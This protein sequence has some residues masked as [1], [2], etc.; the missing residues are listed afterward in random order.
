MSALEK[1][2][3]LIDIGHA[4]TAMRFLLAYLSIQNGEYTLTGSER[5]RQRPVARL[6]EALLGLGARIEYLGQKGFPPLSIKGKPLEGG[7]ITVDGSISSQYISA[8]MMIGPALKNGLVITLENEVVS[9][10]YIRMT[11][12]LMLEYGIGVNLSGNRIEVPPCQ[13]AGRD[14]DTEADWSAAGYW[15]AMAALSKQCNLEVVGL[16]KKS[17]QGDSVLPGLFRPLGVDTTFTGQGIRLTRNPLTLKDF[18]YNFND[19]PDLVQTM[20][21]LCTLRGLPFRMSGTQTLRIKETDRIHALTLEL[22][23]LGVEIVSDPAG[24]WISWNGERTPEST[25]EISIDTYQ[26]H[27]MAMAF[28]PAAMAL[29]GLLINDPAVVNK[30]YPGFWGDLQKVGFTIEEKD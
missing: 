24:K 23:K 17:C 3:G 19:N 6:V 15:Y 7:K 2:G 28:A 1:T 12:E 8:L 18:E 21:V 5:M 20:A 29:S 13:Y 16:N 14:L 25:G 9:S 30:S 26:D 10:S 27:R 22:R 4:G 11:G